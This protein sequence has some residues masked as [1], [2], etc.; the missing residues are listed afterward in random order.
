[1]ST[2]NTLKNA[3]IGAVVTVALS[4]TAVSP[5]LGGGV[6]G[7]LQRESPKRGAR[8]G[9]IS[10]AIA[11]LPF[12]LVLVLGL[13]TLFGTAM[14]GFGVPGGVELVIIFLVVLP[15]L[16]AWNVGLSALGGYLGAYLRSER[17]SASGE[18]VPPDSGY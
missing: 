18:T 15:L 8:I 5:V 12:F 3:V 6:A 11:S 2:E 10:G 7:Y 9:A 17:Q 1:M 13:V 14:G 4:F 16:F